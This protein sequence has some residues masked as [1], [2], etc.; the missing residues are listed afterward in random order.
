MTGIM[1]E[2]KEFY[3]RIG[4]LL[5]KCA[6]TFSLVKFRVED[7]PFDEKVM[8]LQL[9]TI[10]NQKTQTLSY[11]ITREMVDRMHDPEVVFFALTEQMKKQ[12]TG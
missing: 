11:T 8:T 9:A 4:K 12:G 6:E 2:D 3:A 7:S 1:D 10:K 5:Y